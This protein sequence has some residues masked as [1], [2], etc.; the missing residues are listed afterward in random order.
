MPHFLLVARALVVVLL[1]FPPYYR[2]SESGEARAARMTTVAQSI[3][4]ASYEA[5]CTGPFTTAESCE[6]VWAG[7]REDLEV[8]LVIE[9]EFETHFARHVGEG[10]CQRWEC[11]AGRAR[12][13][14][15]NWVNP[16][17]SRETWRELEG[18]GFVPTTRAAV[19]ASS[20]LGEGLKRCRSIEG[21]I[22]FY[23][24]SSCRWAGAAPRFREFLRIRAALP[25]DPPIED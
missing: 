13:Y 1:G 25:V 7:T 11:D 20:V 14:W 24:R 19:A 15:Q 9:G 17:V 2:D 8:L 18:V 3:E 12:H 4:A 5:T 22:S 10:R 16:W 23:A 6:P 21:A